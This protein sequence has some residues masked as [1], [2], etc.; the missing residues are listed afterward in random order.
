MTNKYE[1]IIALGSDGNGHT[2]YWSPSDTV[3]D[4]AVSVIDLQGGIMITAPHGAIIG[5][6]HEDRVRFTD[7][8]TTTLG[9]NAH[10]PQVITIT[11]HEDMDADLDDVLM[12]MNG[13][14]HLMDHDGVNDWGLMPPDDADT[15]IYVII[16]VSDKT[17]TEDLHAAEA[18]VEILRLSRAT[19]IF[20]LLSLESTSTLT[21]EELDNLGMTIS[22]DGKQWELSSG[23]LDYPILF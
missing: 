23:G 9:L 20:M 4:H 2:I 18:I 14:Y 8:L 15:S 22:P 10:R 11:D 17:L 13:R 6:K 7:R 12:E 16:D 19:Q 21:G 5:G 1:N 3:N